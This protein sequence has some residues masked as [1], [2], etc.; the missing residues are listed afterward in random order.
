MN[1]TSVLCIGLVLALS[2]SAIHATTAAILR[3]LC[4]SSSSITTFPLPC[5]LRPQQ[6]ILMNP[7]DPTT[8]LQSLLN[9]QLR[10]HT[11]DTRMFVGDFKCTDKVPNAFPLASNPLHPSISLTPHPGPQHNPRPHLRIQAPIHV[12]R[13]FR[14]SFQPLN[15]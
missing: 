1:H 15:H 2:P 13:Q 3:T 5:D 4:P 12:R 9:R 11:T 14:R 6:P 10:V 7:P 8:Y